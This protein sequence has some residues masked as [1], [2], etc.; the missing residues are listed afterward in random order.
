MPKLAERY[1]RALITGSSSGLGK[2]FS[3]SLVKQ[4]LRVWGTSRYPEQM[5]AT[6]HFV[7]IKLDLSKER[8]FKE[9]FDHW[10]H[11]SGG[12]DVVINNAGFSSFGRWPAMSADEVEDQIRVL[13]TGPMQLSRI[14]LRAMIPRKNGCLVNI[15]SVAGHMPIPFMTA[16]NAGKAGLSAFSQSLMIESPAQPPWIVDFRPGDYQT[17]FNQQMKRRSAEDA[18]CTIVWEELEALMA[19]SPEASKAADDL[20]SAIGQFRHCTQYSGS[21]VQT[22]IASLASRL[23]PHSLN[24]Y[25]LRRYYKIS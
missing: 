3:E 25:V 16:Y 4:G 6:D 1:S 2:A 13:L 11:E 15:S 7:P 10:D 20:I 14:A 21:F 9:W 24:R 18:D 8:D 19:K 5:Q 17:A 23:L 12:F 22:S